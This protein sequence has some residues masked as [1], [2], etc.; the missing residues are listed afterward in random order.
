MSLT[1]KLNNQEH[2]NIRDEFMDEITN[3]RYGDHLSKVFNSS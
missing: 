1:G 3:F 2:E